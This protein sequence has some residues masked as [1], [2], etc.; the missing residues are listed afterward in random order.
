[1][2]LGNQEIQ[3]TQVAVSAAGA[4]VGLVVFGVIIIIAVKPARLV[5]NRVSVEVEALAAALLI[6]RERLL[7]E[8]GVVPQGKMGSRVPQV[9][10]VMQVVLARPRLHFARHS[11]VVQL[12]TEVL[13]VKG[14]LVA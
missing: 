3:E 9:M 7:V 6:H 5:R 1:M 4:V 14:V 8:V 13:L 2:V 11:Q 10:Q 12:V